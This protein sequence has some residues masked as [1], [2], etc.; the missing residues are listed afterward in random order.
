METD[1]K[2]LWT[3]LQK[4]IQDIF[5]NA[6][7]KKFKDVLEKDINGWNWILS[8]HNLVGENYIIIHTK[9]I[10]KLTED[11]KN[12]RKN[13]FLYLKDID[14]LY[15]I[16]NFS[17]LENLRSQIHEILSQD[18][19][20][21]NILSVSQF[22]ISP[23]MTLNQHFYDKNIEGY[24]IFDFQ[25]DPKIAITPCQELKLEFKFNVNNIDDVDMVIEKIKDGDFKISFYHN[26]NE[27]TTHIKSLKNLK[28]EVGTYIQKNLEKK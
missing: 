16:V 1:N 26:K 22:M 13:D 20:G 4:K 3:E 21:E 24:S 28:E 12:L 2:I 8:F 10:F 23:A 5:S 27:K 11:K 18:L 6:E 15:K 9:F 7:V 25:Y 17:D 14:C 19:F